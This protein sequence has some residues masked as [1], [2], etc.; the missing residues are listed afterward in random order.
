MV[1]EIIAYKDYYLDF[2]EKLSE[3]EKMKI[4][5]ALLLF[6][7]TERVPSHFIK[8]I[9]D[10]IYEF[11]VNYGNNEFRIFFIYDGERL[12]ILFNAFRKKTQKTPRSEII[13]AKRLRQEYYEDKNADIQCE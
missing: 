1:R 6:S 4:L 3:K 13:K 7:D 11:R 5:R 8:Y 10:D 2:M 9:E 12:V